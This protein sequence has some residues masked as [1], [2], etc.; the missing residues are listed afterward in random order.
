MP[1]KIQKETEKEKEIMDEIIN[2]EKYCLWSNPLSY[3]WWHTCLSRYNDNIFEGKE[4][5][6]TSNYKYCPYCGK[7]IQRIY[8]KLNE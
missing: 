5:D 7:R 2:L 4:K 1:L 3:T 8:V 6:K